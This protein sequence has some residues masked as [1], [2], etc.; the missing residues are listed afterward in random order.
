MKILIA[1]DEKIVRITLKSMLMDLNFRNDEIIEATNG[2]QLVE[3]IKQYMPDIAFVDIKMPKFNGLEAINIAKIISTNTQWVILTGFPQFDYAKQAIELGVSKYLLKPVTPEDLEITI[4]TLVNNNHQ[5]KINR[6]TMFNR[7]MMDI[8]NDYESSIDSSLFNI[9]NTSHFKIG[10]FYFDVISQNYNVQKK[11]FLSELN[12][13]IENLIQDDTKIALFNI[14]PNKIATVY[15]CSDLRRENND[16]LNFEYINQIKNLINIYKNEHINITL[17]K[18]SKFCK[19][20]EINKN[21]QRLDSYN[22]LRV[23]K[24]ISTIL[25]ID[26]LNQVENLKDLLSLCNHLLSLCSYFNQNKLIDYYN[27]LDQLKKDKYSSINNNLV[28]RQNLSQFVFLNLGITLT[29]SD[30]LSKLI[31]LLNENGKKLISSS[32]NNMKYIDDVIDY[33]SHNYMN[34][35]GINSIAEILNLS[36]NYLSTLF[37]KSM[38]VKFTYYLSQ[39]RI[40]Q[41]K[42][43]LCNTNLSINQISEKIGYHSTRHFTKVFSELVSCYPSEYKKSQ[44]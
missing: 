9:S 2:E 31:I 17:I 40:L 7:Y 41:A 8:Y 36:P 16:L 5:N 23:L 27:V 6:N 38:N 11:K 15:F 43:L 30:D 37:H 22:S 35:I 28:Y 20:S 24:G 42:Y 1:D 44:K 19:S 4:K 13:Y 10:I 33:V 29:N 12:L 25:D 3:L 32:E 39:V 18:D 21:F 34:D 26:M 14:S